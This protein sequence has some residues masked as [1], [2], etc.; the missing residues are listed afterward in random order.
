[1]YTD[2]AGWF[3]MYRK[4][5]QRENYEPV[6]NTTDR[7]N[8]NVYPITAYAAITD[9]PPNEGQFRGNTMILLTDRAQGYQKL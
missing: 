3:M 9:A 8:G 7:I 1:M 6:Y 5:N 4:N 2:T